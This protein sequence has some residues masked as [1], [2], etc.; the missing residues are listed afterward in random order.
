MKFFELTKEACH[1]S[2]KIQ[3]EKALAHLAVAGKVNEESVRSLLFGDY[4]DSERFYD[5][6]T[7]IPELI[8]TMEGSA[9]QF[10]LRKLLLRQHCVLTA[11]S[12]GS[13]VGR[14]LTPLYRIETPEVMAKT[15]E[16]I[17][18][19]IPNLVQICRSIQWSFWTF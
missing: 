9:T 17:V 3:I 8:K 12:Q 19:T 5:E 7:D 15:S 2:F 1:D 4:M 11:F 18:S 10:Y 16:L 14:I 13:G 6:V